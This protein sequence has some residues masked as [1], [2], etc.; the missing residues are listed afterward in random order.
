[1]VLLRESICR[2]IS[3]GEIFLFLK[4]LNSGMRVM[5]VWMS[6]RWRERKS[7]SIWM[8]T[9]K[10]NKT[11]GWSLFPLRRLPS[12]TYKC[13]RRGESSG[14]VSLNVWVCLP[15]CMPVDSHVCRALPI[16]FS[17]WS[18][19]H[20]VRAASDWQWGRTDR[21]RE[22]ARDR[23]V[24]GL[25][26]RWTNG[27]DWLTVSQRHLRAVIGW[28]PQG[29]DVVFCS[30]CGPKRLLIPWMSPTAYIT[31]GQNLSHSLRPSSSPRHEFA[32]ISLVRQL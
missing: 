13:Q 14:C 22:R 10:L 1:M 27:P 20:D 19:D 23:R 25:S 2:N 15:V 6:G 30:H 31:Q 18:W 32:L 4:T 11:V 8:Q 12:V 17:V 21:L 9:I 26:V 28:F 7:A 29:G 24:C 3:A 16:S 5:Y